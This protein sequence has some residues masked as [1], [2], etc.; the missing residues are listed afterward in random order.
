MTDL[1]NLILSCATVGLG[2]SGW[3]LP[4]RTMQKLDLRDGGSTMGL[5]EIRAASGALFVAAGL[6]AVLIEEPVA[7][8]MLG[9]VWLGGAIGR[10]T[11]LG[12]DGRTGR[13]WGFFATEA[14]VALVLISINSAAFAG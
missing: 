2:C 11:S 14:V 9:V 8:A 12:L 5:S 7:Y 6:G 13:K 4:G 3:L 10:A 1:L